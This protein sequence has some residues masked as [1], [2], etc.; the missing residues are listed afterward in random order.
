MREVFLSTRMLTSRVPRV[1]CNKYI[2]ISTNQSYNTV[3]AVKTA[4]LTYM[5]VDPA[6]GFVQLSRLEQLAWL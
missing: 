3:H 5:R 6:P 4:Q 2:Y 1:Q